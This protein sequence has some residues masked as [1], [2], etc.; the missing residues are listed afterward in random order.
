MINTIILIDVNVSLNQRKYREFEK[1]S[2]MASIAKLF[3]KIS[4]WIFF[5]KN[6]DVSQSLSAR[7]AS[8]IYRYI[9]H[10]SINLLCDSIIGKL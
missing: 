2:I 4:F 3:R 10:S 1:C 8:R 7:R 5:P 6:E 9:A